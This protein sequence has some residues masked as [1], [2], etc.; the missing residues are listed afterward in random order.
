MC[1]FYGKTHFHERKRELIAERRAALK[2]NDDKAYEEAV[3]KMTQ[4]EEQL[5]QQKLNKIL[6]KLGVSEQDF[7]RST[8][9][10]GRDQQKSMMLMQMQQQTQGAATSDAAPLSREKTMSTFKAQ[11]EIQM[12]SMDDMMKQGMDQGA[13]QSPEGQMA[14]MMKVM[15]SQAKASDKLW[16]QTGVEEEH[17][18]S[19]IQ[20]NDLQQDKEF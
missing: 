11:L 10:H 1:S 18:N 19:S 5:V 16:E 6:E 14:M 3:F 17:L 8:M 9:M 4:E 20:L 7:Q 2:N 12:E 13:D 15:V